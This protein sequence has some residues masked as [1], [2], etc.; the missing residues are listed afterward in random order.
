M[1]T[2]TLDQSSDPQ[3]AVTFSIASIIDRAGN[4]VSTISNTSDASSVTFDY[5]A[6]QA[7]CCDK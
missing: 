4:P 5:T 3:T 2:H 6:P 7:G 1:A